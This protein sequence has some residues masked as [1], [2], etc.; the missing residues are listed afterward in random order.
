Y[1]GHWFS[2]PS[3]EPWKAF[4]CGLF[5]LPMTPE[6]AVLWREFTERAPPTTA[7]TE[8]WM[9]VGR[10]GGKSRIAALIAVYLAC[11]RDYEP[12]LS[13]G[14]VATIPIISMDKKGS[15]TVMCYAKAFLAVDKLRGRVKG[16][17]LKESV[18]IYPRVQIEVQTA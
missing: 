17:P 1:F 11:F 6:R 16:K 18:S 9:I 8:A 3:W 4:L 2:D 14:E 15:R 13:P 12:Y 5:G 10:R 7:A